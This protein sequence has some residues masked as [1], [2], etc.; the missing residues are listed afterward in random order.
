M[1]EKLNVKEIKM[2]GFEKIILSPKYNNS[3]FCFSAYPLK[4][5]KYLSQL[6]RTNEEA[7]LHLCILTTEQNAKL[8]FIVLR[9]INFNASS[10]L[11]YGY[12]KVTKS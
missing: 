7:L 2:F 4:F 9:T 11:V 5:L 3:V 8:C 6:N 12:I 10:V 1:F